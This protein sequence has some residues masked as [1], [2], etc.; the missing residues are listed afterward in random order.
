MPVIGQI[1]LGTFHPFTFLFL[2]FEAAVAEKLAL[3]FAYLLGLFGAYRLARILPS[4]RLAS[5]TAGFAFAFGGYALG[6][7]SIITYALSHCALPWVA[8]AA[9]RVARARR[10]KDAVLLGALWSLVFLAGDAVSFLLAVLLLAVALIERFS[11]RG[12]ALMALATSVSLLLVGIELIPATAVAAESVRAVGQPS[13][14]LGLTWALHPMRIP[15]L[16]IAGYVPDPVRRQL[17][18]ELFGGRGALFA[19]TLFAGGIA[20]SLA[21][22][23]IGVRSRLGRGFLAL[24]LVGFWLALG[25]HGGLLPLLKRAFW[26]LTRFRYPERYL[27]FFWLGLCPLIALGVDRARRS[28]RSFSLAFVTAALCLAALAILI[29]MAGGARLAWSLAHHTLK[30]GELGKY[31]DATWG[32]SLAWTAALVMA[33]GLCLFLTSGKG[34]SQGMARP[35]ALRILPVLVVAELWRGNGLHLPLIDRA[36]I[37]QPN[38]FVKAIRATASA[39]RPLGRVVDELEFTYSSTVTGP[40]AERSVSAMMHF[41]KPD[42]SGLHGITGINSNLGA[43]SV[44]H[45]LLVGTDD[46]NVIRWAPFLNACFRIAPEDRALDDGEVE[47]AKKAELGIKLIRSP[48]LARAFTA[49]AK[50][51]RGPA[52]VLSLIEAAAAEGSVVWEGPPMSAASSEITWL[53]NEPERIRLRVSSTAPT[54]L[55]LSDEFA[56]GWTARLD[57][58]RVRIHPTML[59]VRGV[60]MPQGTHEVLFEYRTP[61]LGF[62]AAASLFGLL[63]SLGLLLIDRAKRRG[64]FSLPGSGTSFVGDSSSG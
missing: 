60:P 29:R 32:S 1:A 33:A 25:D 37:E 34:R 45:A 35:H 6:V 62:G 51:A 61:R 47:L 41:L 40:W 18:S 56:P 36:S 59:A 27:T 24:A 12:V 23:G 16:L 46:A 9:I 20:L 58:T 8:W 7:S 3:L 28:L 19:T 43:V 38:D 49:A 26:M 48:C 64:H 2:P 57:G 17:V 44:R 53:E 22:A 39:Q 15:E 21:A 10:L 4:S 13:A 52:D 50:S 54:A 30:N 55:V 5:V 42:A 14:T 11:V 63:L 31:L